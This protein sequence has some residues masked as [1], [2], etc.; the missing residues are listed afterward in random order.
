[1]QEKTRLETDLFR[2]NLEASVSKPDDVW[3]ALQHQTGS[4]RG[5]YT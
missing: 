2:K 1:M 5:N 3:G 4:V